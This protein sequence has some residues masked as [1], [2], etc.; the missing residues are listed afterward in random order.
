MKTLAVA[1]MLAF[2]VGCAPPN[3]PAPEKA[4]YNQV[5]FLKAV[6]ALQDAAIQAN[7]Q[8]TLRDD[9]EILIVTATR[10]I[11]V[12][13]QGGQAHWTQTVQDTWAHLINALSA[14]VRTTYD[15]VIKAVDILVAVLPGGSQETR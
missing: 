10:A 2:V 12:A 1:L 13:V 15:T 11:A 5:T 4:V 14:G 7:H 9:Q 8:G 6:A 3:L